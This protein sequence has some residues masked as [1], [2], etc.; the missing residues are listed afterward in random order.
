MRSQVV[1]VVGPGGSGKSSLVRAI[2]GP[3]QG[4]AMRVGVRGRLGATAIAWHA[5][6]T[7]PP[8]VGQ[9]PRIQSRPLYRYTTMVQ[10]RC[11]ADVVGRLDGQREV[12]LLDQGPV[13]LM[14]IVQRALAQD[15][16]ADSRLFLGYWEGA[17]EFWA[18]TLRLVVV[19]DAPDEVLLERI[20]SRGTRHP[21]LERPHPAAVRHLAAGRSSRSRILEALRSYRPG[22]R[23]LEIDTA[24][25]GTEDI[26]RLV[27]GR[28]GLPAA[29]T[30]QEATSRRVRPT[31]KGPGADATDPSE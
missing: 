26:A 16:C 23:V 27:R 29:A 22:L 2:T 13:Y 21:L 17:L 28:L 20:R 8:L 10:L 14:S 1:E 9:L 24:T 4:E 31:G 6:R 18:R 19:L 11:Y 15:G 30:D 5:A 7:I 12:L 25:S 3:D